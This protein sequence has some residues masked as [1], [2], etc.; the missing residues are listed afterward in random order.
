MKFL[1]DID[2]QLFK[3]AQ[4][5]TKAKKKKDAILVPMREYIERH[6]REDLAQ[7]IG[8]FD[9]DMSLEDLKKTRKQWKRP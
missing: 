6:K 2:D 3:E 9:F 5:L 8:N 1:I 7:L 4:H